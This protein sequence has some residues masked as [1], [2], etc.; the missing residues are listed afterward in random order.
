[1]F[2]EQIKKFRSDYIGDDGRPETLIA[3]VC[4]DDKDHRGHKG[5]SLTAK[6]FT[7]DR[8]WSEPTVIHKSGETLWCNGG[9]C[10]HN[11]IAKR[12]PQLAPL[13]K[14]HLCSTDGPIH[15]VPNTVYHA[16]DKDC[17]GLRKGE[18]RQILFGGD[19]GQPCWEYVIIDKDGN[20]HPVYNLPQLPH[21]EGKERNLDAA[22]TTAIWPDATDEDLTAPGLEERLEARL[23][24]LM[25]EFKAAV[26]SLGFTY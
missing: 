14:W 19:P 9:G 7:K 26:E 22:R 8:R 1:M 15:Y 20:E 24:R 3:S 13:I 18:K 6:L 12:F 10:L 5:L 11:E 21:T 25:K 2:E 4:Y 16:G 17:W 23:P